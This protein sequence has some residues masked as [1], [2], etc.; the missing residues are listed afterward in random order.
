MNKIKVYGYALLVVGI[1]LASTF[2]I[3]YKLG[4]GISVITLLFYVSIVG[5]LT[6]F[7]MMLAKKGTHQLKGMFK[8]RNLLFALFTTGV[9]VFTLEPLLLAY[10]THYVSA[11]LT[12]VVFRT[13]PIMLVLLAP[14][15]IRE[16]ITKWEVAGV[17]IGFMGLG[18]T[19]VGGT[20]I[21]LPVYELPFVGIILVAAFSEAL[22]AT[23]SKRYNYELTASIFVYNVISLLIFAP[24]ALYTNAWQLP[25][26]TSSVLF[27][28]LFLG[29]VTEGIFEYIYYEAFRLVRTSIV[30]TSYIIC[31]FIT[32]LLSAVFLGEAVEPYYVVIA[33][34]VVAGVLVQKFAPKAVGNFIT[35][36][37]KDRFPLPLYDV[38]A[39]FVNTRHPI[40]MKTMKGNGRVLAFS[41]KFNEPIGK[42][43][44]RLG[45]LGHESLMLFTDRSD[46]AATQNEIE[47][48]REIVGCSDDE[49]LVFGSG[50]PEETAEKFFD[51]KNSIDKGNSIP[52]SN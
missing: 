37:K 51:I 16:K 26:I 11:D 20:A 34:T 43:H 19:L 12:A 49:L 1:F 32:M 4:S 25:A 14:F 42:I 8:N 39:A 9:L 40:I 15:V 7:L 41:T 30:G 33:I 29:I 18:V 46:G 47:F 6:S 2:P 31:S 24:L 44:E 52:Q 50:D 5:T 27:A 35:S 3:A 36:K 45:R 23:I 10:A 17:I 48:V 13:W 28:I 22:P 21:S 38:T